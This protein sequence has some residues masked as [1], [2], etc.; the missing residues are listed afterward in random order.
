MANFY[1][2]EQFHVVAVDNGGQCVVVSTANVASL[3]PGMVTL[4][5]HHGH[6]PPANNIQSLYMEQP[7]GV[8]SQDFTDPVGAYCLLPG[9][10]AMLPGTAYPAFTNGPGSGFVVHGA[11]PN[12]IGHNYTVHG[13][14]SQLLCHGLAQF[15]APQLLHATMPGNMATGHSTSLVVAPVPLGSQSFTGVPSYCYPAQ[16][17]HVSGPLHGSHGHPVAGHFAP[18]PLRPQQAPYFHAGNVLPASPVYQPGFALRPPLISNHVGSRLHPAIFG[19]PVP[20]SRSSTGA[21]RAPTT[22]H[23]IRPSQTAAVDNASKAVTQAKNKPP[24]PSLPALGNTTVT[25][26]A[27]KELPVLMAP[28]GTG[29]SALVGQSGGQFAS[30]KGSAGELVFAQFQYGC[31]GALAGVS[32]CRLFLRGDGPDPALLRS[33][34]W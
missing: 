19:A 11:G 7:P 23:A 30:Q 6:P 21:P 16:C 10:G 34:P 3:P 9:N 17:P 24:F 28:R 32:L 31:V 1:Q 15:A 8:S 12:M 13:G 29:L 5:P 22:F 26:T 20:L 14:P 18:A 25:G 33:L 4:P 2:N 27:G